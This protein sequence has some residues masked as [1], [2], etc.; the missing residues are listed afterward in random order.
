[1]REI[2]NWLINEKE[3][4]KRKKKEKKRLINERIQGSG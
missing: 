2:N 3:E 1:M 4:T